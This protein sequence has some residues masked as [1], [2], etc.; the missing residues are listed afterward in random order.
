MWDGKSSIDVTKLTAAGLRAYGDSCG[1][2]LARGHA[3]SGDRVAMA[4]F[5]GDDDDF[6]QAIDSGRVAAVAG[7]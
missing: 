7:I 2:T 5:L 3:R 1:W 6:D 4:A